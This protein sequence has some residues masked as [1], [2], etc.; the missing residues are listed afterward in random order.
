MTIHKAK[1]LEFPVVIF[2]F[3]TNDAR[4]SRN[5]LWI[6]LDEP[7][8][9]KLPIGLVKATKELT[10]AGYD[11]VLNTE[12]GRTCLDLLNMMYVAM[13]RPIERLFILTT[14]PSK[15]S[16]SISMPGLFRSFLENQGLWNDTDS[17]YTF[18]FDKPRQERKAVPDK[19]AM[20]LKEFISIDWRT[21]LRLAVK[22]P[23]LWDTEDPS[24]NI[25]WGNLVHTILSRVT[26][27]DNTEQL[28]GKLSFEG[29]I[30]PELEN[31]L[32]QKVLAVLKHPKL[33]HLFLQDNDIRVESELLLPDGTIY[34]PDRVVISSSHAVVVEYKTGKPKPQHQQQVN[35][36]ANVLTRMGYSS[37]EKLLVYLDEEIHVLEC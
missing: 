25:Q 13:T 24:R 16:E 1:G 3:A 8:L 26:S 22:A 7:M 5:Y 11:E 15:S 14:P 34:R 33:A 2:P 32:K 19:R 17:I 10:E 29:L 21:K 18:G 6:D 31:E 28:F 30:R 27:I 20:Q 9:E 23:E 4:T 35:E 37:V 12:T 36:Y